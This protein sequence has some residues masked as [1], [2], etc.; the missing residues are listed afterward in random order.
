AQSLAENGIAVV[1]YDKRGVASSVGAI[2]KEEDL[3]FDDYVNDVSAWIELL[4][5]DK[6]FEE[7]VVLGHSEGSLLGAA[8]IVNTGKVSKYISLAGIGEPANVTIRKQLK[9]QPDA[10]VIPAYSIMDEL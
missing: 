8:A 4:S 6:R 1:R 2:K 3:R 10:I 9:A 7:I 5:T